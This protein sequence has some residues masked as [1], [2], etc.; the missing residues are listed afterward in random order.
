MVGTDVVFSR[1]SKMSVWGDGERRRVAEE[2]RKGGDPEPA[3][4]CAEP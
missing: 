2:V 3:G 1:R 4:P